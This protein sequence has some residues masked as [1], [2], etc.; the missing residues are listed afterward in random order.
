M[1]WQPDLL[2]GSDRQMH[3]LVNVFLYQLVWFLCVFGGNKGAITALPLLL[4]HLVMTRIR[5]ADLKMMVFMFFLGQLV[6]GT[7]QLV[8][9]FSF[10]DPGFPIPLWLIVI[11]LG[12]AITPNHSLAWLKTRPLLSA[13]F[14]A[15]GGPAA[16]WAGAQF[17]AASI[18]WPLPQALAFLAV[19]WAF[20]W[21]LVMYVS[22]LSN[23]IGKESNNGSTRKNS[24][25]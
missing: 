1:W 9:F 12:L 24:Q 16:Y 17:G 22:V 5:W 3:I 10:A 15:V 23:H 7:L 13:A 25:G 4:F 14:G 6:D 8:G 2:I 21:S 18:T 20:N 11:W 19:V